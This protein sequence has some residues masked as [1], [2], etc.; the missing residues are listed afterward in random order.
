MVEAQKVSSLVTGGAASAGPPLGPALGPLGVN[1]MEIIKAINDKTKD[2]E[3]MK[4]PVTV[5]V[6]PDTKKWEIEIGI[7]SAA[8]LLLKEAGVQKGTGTPG[9]A[10]VG[11]ITIDSVVKVAKTKLEKSYASSLKS[12]AKTIVG[13]CLSLGIKVEG[14]TPKE[15]TAEI[16]EG[17]WDSKLN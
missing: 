17:K 14:K 5:S 1:I 6:F 7:P 4:V 12:V 3:G 16:N 2:F 8:A 13:T 11:D 10:W 9:T 15:I